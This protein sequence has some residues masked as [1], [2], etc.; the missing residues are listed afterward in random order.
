MEREEEQRAE[1]GGC[2][3]WGAWKQEGGGRTPSGSH[4]RAWVVG[5]ASFFSSSPRKLSNK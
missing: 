4:E 3:H 5:L 2:L 1:G